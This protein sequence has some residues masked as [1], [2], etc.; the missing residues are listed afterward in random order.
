MAAVADTT[1]AE[2]LQSR[3]QKM[4]F[5]SAVRSGPDAL[6]SGNGVSVEQRRTDYVLHW[7]DGAERFLIN[8]SAGVKRRHP[9]TD[10]Y[11]TYVSKQKRRRM[12]NCDE[13]QIRM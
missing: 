12:F 11:T 9:E 3:G 6:Q 2:L 1:A 13:K 4:K 10:E 5:L 7:V 8:N